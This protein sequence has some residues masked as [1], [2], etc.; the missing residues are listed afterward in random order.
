VSEAWVKKLG[1]QV[2]KSVKYLLTGASNGEIPSSGTTTISL[3]F[4][5]VK[6]KQTCVVIPDFKYELILGEDFLVQNKVILDYNDKNLK[7]RGKVI[8]FVAK[9]AFTVKNTNKI[10]RIEAKSQRTV[11]AEVMGDFKEG[12]EMYFEGGFIDAEQQ[13]F[14]P[15]SV[16]RVNKRG[17]ICLEVSNLAKHPKTLMPDVAMACGQKL[18][19]N[20][21]NFTIE[22]VDGG[23]GSS[24]V[25]EVGMNHL[26]LDEKAEIRQIIKD[27]EI[28]INQLGRVKGLTTSIDTTDASPINVRQY[29]LPIAKRLEAR[30]ETQKMLLAGVIRESTSPWN[31]PVVLVKKPNGGTRFAIDF[32]QLNSVTKRQVYPMPR[33][34]DCLN[35][36]GSG[37]HFSLLD[38]QS[39]FW[40]V[41]LDED[42]KP[43]TAFSVEG[44]G[45]YHFEVMPYG[46]TNAAAVFQRMMDHVLRGLHWTHVLCYIDDVIVFGANREEHNQRLGVVLKKLAEANLGLNL[47]KCSFGKES[48]K[49]LG[50]II[51]GGPN[52][53]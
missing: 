33:I 9:N 43:K 19:K 22:G 45:H 30:A 37:T 4:G 31:S 49:Y 20:G 1:A 26:S 5:T 34:D 17:K 18:E 32:R 39:A 44:M 29:R 42:S 15:R 51:G 3:D 35:S 11:V 40:Q 24:E 48:V 28:K 10:M 50:H 46:L 27:S 25:D 13:L 53:S 47:G 41:E 12:Q 21:Q 7:I 23:L 6:V 16:G 14:M 36:L 38:L 8:P 52:K 2:D